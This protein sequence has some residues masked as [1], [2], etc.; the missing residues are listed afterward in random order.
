MGRSPLSLAPCRFGDDDKSPDEV[1]L[2]KDALRKNDILQTP[3][4]LG[5]LLVNV[6]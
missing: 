5:L 6:L 4:S 2:D 1:F 3:C